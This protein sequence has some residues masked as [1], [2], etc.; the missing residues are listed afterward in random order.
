MT[1]LEDE[2]KGE[3]EDEEEQEGDQEFVFGREMIGRGCVRE[4]SY[5]FTRLKIVDDIG[6]KG[7]GA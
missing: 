3:G 1:E 2:G 5:S 6:G 4:I 7:G